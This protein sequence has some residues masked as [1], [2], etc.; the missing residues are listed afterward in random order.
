MQKERQKAKN[1]MKKLNI[2]C[3][4]RSILMA[5]E[6]RVMHKKKTNIQAPGDILL[7]STQKMV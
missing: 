5:G 1:S 7:A 6:K 4:L 3:P 2:H